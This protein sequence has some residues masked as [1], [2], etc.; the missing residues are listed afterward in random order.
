[1]RTVPV[2]LVILAFT[3]GSEKRKEVWLFLLQWDE[4]PVPMI[5]QYSDISLADHNISSINMK[6]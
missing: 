4:E 5:P 2:I 1:M 3:G 6:G